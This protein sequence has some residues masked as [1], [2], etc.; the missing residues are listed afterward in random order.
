MQRTPVYSFANHHCRRCSFMTLLGRRYLLTTSPS[1]CVPSCVCLLL[2]SVCAFPNSP[3]QWEHPSVVVVVYD[4]TNEQS[5]K[6]CAKWLERVRAQK[7]EQPFPGAYAH[8]HVGPS[9]KCTHQCWP[10]PRAGVLVANKT[11]LSARRVVGEA[12]G[13]NFAADKGLQYFECSAVSPPVLAVLAWSSEW[14]RHMSISLCSC[15][16]G[17]V[18]SCDS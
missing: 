8:S 4:V 18:L 6:S 1:L 9:H 12:A 3:P 2:L 15:D 5:F 14:A 17:A 16:G 10:R 13:R 11:D 7:P